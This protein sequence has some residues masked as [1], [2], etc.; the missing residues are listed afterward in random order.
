M[1]ASGEYLKAIT[2]PVAHARLVSIY[3]TSVSGPAADALNQAFTQTFGSGVQPLANAN[4]AYDAVI[5]LALAMDRAGTTDG[6]SV[7]K[8]MKQVTNPPGTA[9]YTYQSCLKLVHQG[10]RIDYEG[11]SG[12]LNYDR[13]N[14]VFGAY[15]AFRATLSGDEE[16]VESLSASELAAATPS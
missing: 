9:C 13:Y 14:N 2:Y 1:T 4:Y 6:P 7:V 10:K 12:D 8:V 15:G 5:S 11:A 3:G 16:Q